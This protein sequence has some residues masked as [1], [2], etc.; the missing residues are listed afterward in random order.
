MGIDSSVIVRPLS[1]IMTLLW[2]SL[3]PA[4]CPI[5]VPQIVLAARTSINRFENATAGHP[6]AALELQ[7]TASV[8]YT[9]CCA[10]KPCREGALGDDG[11]TYAKDAHGWCCKPKSKCGGF[12][13]YRFP[14]GAVLGPSC[15][16]LEG[17]SGGRT[18]ETA[19]TLEMLKGALKY[20]CVN[21][22]ASKQDARKT[23][24][25]GTGEHIEWVDMSPDS[26]D[27]D[28]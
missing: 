20:E 21:A 28:C 5:F 4:L 15:E 1:K 6:F 27:G 12:S 25:P 10:E 16:C 18:V 26:E 11:L 9:C 3:V 22:A 14:V 24:D 23:A 8:A 19:T 17:L 13:S 2:S 7:A